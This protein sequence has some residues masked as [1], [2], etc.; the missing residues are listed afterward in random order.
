MKKQLLWII[1][2]YVLL[3]PSSV[4]L[5]AQGTYSYTTTPV[6]HL[7]SPFNNGT[8]C[9]GGMWGWLDPGINCLEG[10]ERSHGTPD[11]FYNSSGNAPGNEDFIRM[12]AA[13]CTGYGLWPPHS[14]MT[15]N[16]LGE[17]VYHPFNFISNAEYTIKVGI[18]KMDRSTANSAYQG[19][20]GNDLYGKIQVWA[21]RNIPSFQSAMPAGGYFDHINPGYST[22]YNPGSS[23]YKAQLLGEYTITTNTP[24][25]SIPS[26]AFATGGPVQNKQWT[27]LTA[28]I[29]AA[30]YDEIMINAYDI[31]SP[32]TASAMVFIDYIEVCLGGDV[33]YNTSTV[34][35]S[36]SPPYAIQPQTTRANTIVAG[37]PSAS[38]GITVPIGGTFVN[39]TEFS[40]YSTILIPNFYAFPIEDNYF[41][42]EA[43]ELECSSSGYP[44]SSG[45]SKGG[46]N[47]SGNSY[48]YEKT[49]KPYGDGNDTKKH[50][51]IYPNPTTGTFNIEM[52]QRG[53]YTIQVMNM[54]GSTVYEGKLT[55]EQKK[56]IQLDSQLPP[57]NYTLHISGE[58]L[59]HVERI[60][61]TK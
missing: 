22:Y 35:S 26:T 14:I 3:I 21:I 56:S 45:L 39:F 15:S 1:V 36:T 34:S 38:P 61:L 58:G 7:Y 25:T 5:F 54:L 50:V 51:H 55:D 53:N 13:H 2:L 8:S 60:T 23:T 33:V 41:L 30:G 49:I 31:D 12:G 19:P 48:Y 47:T 59:R 40:A 32:Y 4:K 17:G 28:P 11:V 9:S 37:D 42:I 29:N 44:A 10:W 24:A 52:P 43:H 6:S 27:F 20:S 46:K 18:K 57:G 16:S